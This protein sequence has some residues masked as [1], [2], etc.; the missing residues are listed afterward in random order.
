MDK[1]TYLGGLEMKGEPVQQGQCWGWRAGLRRSPRF[2]LLLIWLVFLNG[3]ASLAFALNPFQ[4]SAGQVVMEAENFDAKIPRSGK[5]WNFFSST[6][7]TASGTGYLQVL[8]NTGVT[9]DTGYATTAPELQYQINFTATGTFYV[10]ILG[11]GPTLS[12]DTLHAGI[13]GTAPA[14]AAQIGKFPNSWTWKGTKQV[15]SQPATIVVSTPGV[16]TFNLWM[17]EDGFMVDKILLTKSSSYVPSGTG[18]PESPRG[19]SNQPPVITSVA[20]IAGS[21]YYEQD[22]VTVTV[23]ASD[24]NGDAL[25]Y[26]YKVNGVIKQAWTGSST[27]S[28]TTA[29]RNYGEKVIDVEVKDAPGAVTASQTKIFFFHKPKEPP[30]P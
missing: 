1:E 6:G 8:P 18:P 11:K 26:Q 13:D 10:W 22:P 17:R 4:E 20:P 27:Y 30:T 5:D 25:Q 14:S 28:L 21:K 19:G 15:G 23:V 3:S 12:D 16:H 9:Q 2:P 29:D 24:P 7:T